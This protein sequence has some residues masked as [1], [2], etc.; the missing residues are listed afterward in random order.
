MGLPVGLRLSGKLDVP[1]F[2]IYSRVPRLVSV[3]DDGKPSAAGQF[4]SPCSDRTMRKLMAALPVYIPA[5][6]TAVDSEEAWPKRPEVSDAVGRSDKIGRSESL[7]FGCGATRGRR[8][9]A[10]TVVSETVL[11]EP[12]TDAAAGV[13]REATTTRSRERCSCLSPISMTT[14]SALD[15]ITLKGQSAT[16]ESL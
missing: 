8:L 15:E 10:T 6:V 16:G 7:R 14:V 2:G 11:T 1:V 12:G 4:S 9:T 13:G 3:C 5:G